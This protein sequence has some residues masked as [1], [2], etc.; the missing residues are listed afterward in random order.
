MAYSGYV[1]TIAYFAGIF[2]C[3][4]HKRKNLYLLFYAQA[5]K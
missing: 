2:Y 4:F 3:I 5:L 1:Y